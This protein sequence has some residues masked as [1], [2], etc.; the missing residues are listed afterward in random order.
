MQ[1]HKGAKTDLNPEDSEGPRIDTDSGVSI[2]NG[3][4]D[5]GNNNR[6]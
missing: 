3:E 1:L 2:K 6:I 5:V 4:K